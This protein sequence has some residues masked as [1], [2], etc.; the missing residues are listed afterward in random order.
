MCRIIGE[1]SFVKELTPKGE[2]ELLTSLSKAGGPDHTGFWENGFCRFGFNRLAI[3]DLSERGNQ[4]VTSPSRRY[5]MMLNGEVYN[6]RQLQ[7]QYNIDPSTL[8]SS[9]DTEVVAHLLDLLP[10]EKVAQ[11]LDGMFAI[12]VWDSLEQC[13]TL[14]RDFAGI[15]PIH[16]GINRNGVVFASQYNQVVRHRWFRNNDFRAD[17]LAD[18]LWRHYMP[19][20]NGLI[21][22]TYQVEPGQMV[23]FKL[24]GDIKK[25]YYWRLPKFVEPTLLNMKDVVEYVDHHLNKVV[26]QQLVSD[27]PLGAFLSGGVDSP[28]ICHYA[29]RNINSKLKTFTIG[30]E[31]VKHDETDLA[32]LFSHSLGSDGWFE[33]MDAR[34]AERIFDEAM[35]T[36]SEPFADFSIIPTYLVSKLAR[37]HVTVA[38]SG[39]GGDELFYGY[40]RFWAVGKNIK[41]QSLPYYLKY[42]FYGAD[43][44]LFGSKHINSLVLTPTQGLSH[45]SLH[46]RTNDDKFNLIAPGLERRDMIIY[47]EYQ[48]DVIDDESRLIQMMRYGEFYDMMQK[49]LRKVDSASMGNGLEVRVP[50]LQKSFIEASLQIDYQLSYGQNKSKMV[51]RE[52]L[53]QHFPNINYNE[54]KRGF[55]V[56]LRK[57]IQTDLQKSFREVLSDRSLTNHFGFSDAGIQQLIENHVSNKEDNKWLLFTLNSLYRWQ[58]KLKG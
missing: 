9:S 38:L 19:A 36:L 18:Y 57:W 5:V 24:N 17:V 56:P 48:Y 14:V 46:S 3:L 26:S 7:K 27:V 16:Y 15:K 1:L 53:A 37:Q 49:T 34:Y 23:T 45:Q 8:R 44:I 21:D 25:Y 28:L 40:E 4:P 20:P 43:R 12:A 50:F 13:L 22:E 51:L 39:D 11:E 54:P 35:D 32:R 42:L 58:Q 29:Q 10:L 6:Y 47:P 30:S 41:Y 31:S 2:F 52:L 33:K 55:T